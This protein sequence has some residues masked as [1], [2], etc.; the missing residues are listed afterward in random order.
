MTLSTTILRALKV[1]WW[2]A[3]SH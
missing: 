1:V 3:K 2:P